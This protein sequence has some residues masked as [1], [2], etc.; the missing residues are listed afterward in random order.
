MFHQRHLLQNKEIVI[1]EQVIVGIPRL[2]GRRVI[3]R[4]ELVE[5]ARWGLG[6]IVEQE[7]DP[8]VN[9][10]AVLRCQD[11]GRLVVRIVVRE[12]AQCR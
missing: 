1:L 10:Q 7:H 6:T 9:H 12:V 5:Y 11:D 4:R 8:E 3:D 2:S